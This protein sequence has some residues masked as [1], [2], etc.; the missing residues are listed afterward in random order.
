MLH[1][2]SKY[3]D[4]HHSLQMTGVGGRLRSCLQ[5][6][7]S[8]IGN[9]F[10]VV[11]LSHPSQYL[12]LADIRHSHICVATANFQ[13]TGLFLPFVLRLNHASNGCCFIGVAMCF[14]FHWFLHFQVCRWG[15]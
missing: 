1:S 9:A 6:F 4:K 7:L 13:A 14:I 10:L 5:G 2:Q 8:Q 11:A 12:I 3:L 15:R